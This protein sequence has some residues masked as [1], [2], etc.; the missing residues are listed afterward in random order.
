M[1]K[2]STDCLLYHYNIDSEL[3]PTFAKMHQLANHRF[4]KNGSRISY[5]WGPIKFK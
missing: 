5:I 3:T 4:N 2:I 1:V